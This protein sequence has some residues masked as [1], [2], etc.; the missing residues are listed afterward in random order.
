MS[1]LTQQDWPQFQ[2]PFETIQLNAISPF[3]WLT[4]LNRLKIDGYTIFKNILPNS[5]FLELNNAFDSLKHH[6]LKPVGIVT[7]PLFWLIMDALRPMIEKIL[8]EPYVILPETW[9]WD[10]APN[11]SNQGW[12]PHREKLFSCVNSEGLPKSISC[13]F[14]ITEA[15]PE[16]S[17]MY[18]LPASDDP[19]YPIGKT[20]FDYPIQAIRALPASPGDVVVFNHNILHWGSQSSQWGQIN[21]RAIAFETQINSIAH[22]NSPVIDP[23]N[24]PS[25]NECIALYKQLIHQYK[26]IDY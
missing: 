11:K 4:H 20:K 2:T 19:Y 14:P 13:W 6:Q 23:N 16:N 7:H 3:Q 17:C 5:I 9:A 21:R 10:I 25:L 12:A 15:T 18:V 26:H 1:L 24:F 8:A 22:Y